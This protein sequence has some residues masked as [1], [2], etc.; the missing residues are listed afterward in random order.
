MLKIYSFSYKLGQQNNFKP[1]V[2]IFDC[3]N[4]LNPFYD[5]ALKALDGTHPDV[6]EFVKSTVGSVIMR[7]DALK[8]ALNS[9]KGADANKVIGFGCTGGHHRS[10]T[11]AE[12][13]ADDLDSLG[14]V[15]ELRHLVI[16]K[17][18]KSKSREAE[19]E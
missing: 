9:L 5:P 15:F 17:T 10:V 2:K 19:A 6:Q 3:R 14:F 7:N 1:E 8:Y 18:R 4:L 11:M 13:L 16:S 12:A